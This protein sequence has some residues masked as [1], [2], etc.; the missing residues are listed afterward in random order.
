MKMI[1]AA[2]GAAFLVGALNSAADIPEI[3]VGFGQILD[4]PKAAIPQPE[5]P[6][7]MTPPPPR[8]FNFI[9][10]PFAVSGGAA[11]AAGLNFIAVYKN[12]HSIDL[13]R[14]RISPDDSGS[15]QN[16]RLG[17]QY[18]LGSKFAGI[19]NA[20]AIRYSDT[21]NIDEIIEFIWTAKKEFKIGENGVDVVGNAKWQKRDY[22]SNSIDDADDFG[23]V[24]GLKTNFSKNWSF[25]VDHDF[26]NDVNGGSTSS[27]S[28]SYSMNLDQSS[29]IFSFGAD[30]HD[31]Y[32]LGLIYSF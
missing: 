23:F 12:K 2:A 3:G 28:A 14:M 1:V 15:I 22:D 4:V 8:N 5:R 19:K 27:F 25:T 31:S 16:F 17:Y 32:N 20:A 7:W 10:A 13:R 30:D 26:E 6:V 29:L 18:G 11:D 21:E 9:F 24:L